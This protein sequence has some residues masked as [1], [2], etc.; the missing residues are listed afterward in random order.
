VIPEG[1]DVD[2]ALA[3]EDAAQ[4]AAW[5]A[6]HHEQADSAWLKVGKKGSAR[7][8]ISATEA[9]DVALCY[10]WIDSVRRSSDDDCFLQRY[11]RRRPNSSWSM[12]NIERAEAL[13]AA[14]HMQAAGLAEVNAAKA[15]GRWAAAYKS[16]RK[17]DVPDDLTAALATNRPAKEFFDQLGRTDQYLVVLPLLKARTPKVRAVRL[18]KAI[19]AL[20]AGRGPRA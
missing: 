11:S 10:G 17:A 12:V 16:Q 6:A 20:T 8:S 14:G 18:Q 3:F 1:G 5:L 13:I 2:D 7:K 4:W 9:G 15:D 19:E